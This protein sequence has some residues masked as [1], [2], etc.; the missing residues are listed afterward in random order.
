MQVWLLYLVASLVWLLLMWQATTYLYLSKIKVTTVMVR[1]M[2]CVDHDA[3]DY[4][5]SWFIILVLTAVPTK[6]HRRYLTMLINF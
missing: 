3:N 4:L 5:K 2:A 6:S 1:G